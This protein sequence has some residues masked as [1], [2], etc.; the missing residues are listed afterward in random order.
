MI[1]IQ[2]VALLKV[3]SYIFTKKSKVKYHLRVD[4]IAV[5]IRKNGRTKK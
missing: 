5:N 3:L 4:I 2:V 1:L